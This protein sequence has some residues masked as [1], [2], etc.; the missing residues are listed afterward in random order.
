MLSLI[1][2]V[3]CAVVLDLYFNWLPM[4]TIGAAV[5]FIPLST[6]VVIRAALSEMDQLIEKIAPHEVDAGDI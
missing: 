3:I 6:F 4:L 1:A 2:P 5:L